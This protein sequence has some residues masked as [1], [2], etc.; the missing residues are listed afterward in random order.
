MLDGG[1]VR[2][3]RDR[4]GHKWR[5][6]QSDTKGTDRTADVPSPVPAGDPWHTALLRPTHSRSCPDPSRR[7]NLLAFREYF[8]H[9][10]LVV[11]TP[12]DAL[13]F[14]LVLLHLIETRAGADELETRQLCIVS[15]LAF[16]CLCRALTPPHAHYSVLLD[17]LKTLCTKLSATEQVRL[18]PENSS[19]GPP[20]AMRMI[21]HSAF[22]AV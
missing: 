7:L 13:D 11:V 15:D 18:C 6:P 3:T 12:E 19:G 9:L 2:L 4:R 20:H 10:H 16:Q 21:E 17:A 22:G 1:R 14:L 5:A 8:E